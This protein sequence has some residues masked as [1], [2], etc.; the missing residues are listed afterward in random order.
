MKS[1]DE[2]VNYTINACWSPDESS[3]IDELDIK[4][5]NSFG[6]KFEIEF[7]ESQTPRQTSKRSKAAPARGHYFALV[8]VNN[9]AFLLFTRRGSIRLFSAQACVKFL[10]DI[11]YPMPCIIRSE[12]EP[13]TWGGIIEE[14]TL[15]QS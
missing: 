15:A 12:L 8:T 5:F 6:T 4:K 14:P 7:R 13:F 10:R 1:L 11:E 2:L 3:T 9:K